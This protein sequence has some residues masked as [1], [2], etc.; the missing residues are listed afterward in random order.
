MKRVISDELGL[1]VKKTRDSLRVLL[2]RAA[3]GW[4][5]LLGN[6]DLVKPIEDAIYTP[7]T[8]KNRDFDVI[9]FHRPFGNHASL[10]RKNAALAAYL[11]GAFDV[12]AAAAMALQVVIFD[13]PP[14]RPALP[15]TLYQTPD[16]TAIALAG[17]QQEDLGRFLHAYLT[18]TQ[19]K[20]TP[21]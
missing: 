2:E 11:Q 17:L 16:G 20:G 4:L 10:A 14:G 9:L 1:K 21:T 3:S 5:I 6:P 15:G 7:G 19:Y 12:P 18:L 8:P 13:P